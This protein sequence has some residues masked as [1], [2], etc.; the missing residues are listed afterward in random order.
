MRYVYC[1][2]PPTQ[3]LK[4]FKSSEKVLNWWINFIL[5]LSYYSTFFSNQKQTKRYTKQECCE[6][7]I[8]YILQPHSQRKTYTFRIYIPLYCTYIRNGA[9][10]LFE[11]PIESAFVPLIVLLSS[12]A[13]CNLL[14]RFPG[15]GQN[16]YYFSN[17]LKNAFDKKN[18]SVILTFITII[19]NN[20]LVN[21]V[22]VL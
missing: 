1:L 22:P 11:Q 4:N 10:I 5:L 2:Q 18:N 17:Y 14:L 19:S 8:Y 12:T 9:A 3:P 16:C 21:F 15:D 6:N 20:Y 7:I 13:F